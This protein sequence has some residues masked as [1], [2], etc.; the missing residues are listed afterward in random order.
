MPRKQGSLLPWSEKISSKSTEDLLKISARAGGD[1]FR[2][3][4]LRAATARRNSFL[5]TIKKC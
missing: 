5:L 1:V 4:T 2:R 3:D